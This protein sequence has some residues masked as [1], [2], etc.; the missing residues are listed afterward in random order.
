MQKSVD[1][2]PP[3]PTAREKSPLFLKHFCLWIY[4]RL[5]QITQ[6]C[7]TTVQKICRHL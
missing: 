4:S 3:S 1:C 7:Y 5:W 2:T 6:K